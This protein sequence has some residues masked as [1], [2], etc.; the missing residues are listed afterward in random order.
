LGKVSFRCEELSKSMGMDDAEWGD[1]V[2]DF[3]TRYPEDSNL[4]VALSLAVQADRVGFRGY[5]EPNSST[6]E[7]SH[8][9]S[10]VNG[11]G[12]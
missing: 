11:D 4:I 10:G 9:E 6:S 3:D 1:Y 5:K 8:W 12:L 7:G 2:E